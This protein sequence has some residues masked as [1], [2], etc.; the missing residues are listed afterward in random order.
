MQNELSDGVPPPSCTP[1]EVDALGG[2]AA[3]QPQMRERLLEEARRPVRAA[4]AAEVDSHSLEHY[5]TNARWSALAIV[6]AT[7]CAAALFAPQNGGVTLALWALIVVLSAAAHAVTAARLV[8]AA[9]MQPHPLRLRVVN[10]TLWL[11][12]AAIGFGLLPFIQ[13]ASTIDIAA[14]LTLLASLGVVTLSRMAAVFTP[15]IGFALLTMVP[16]SAWVVYGGVQKNDGDLAVLGASALVLLGVVLIAHRTLHRTIQ[17][18]W[19]SSME[20]RSL[21]RRLQRSNQELFADRA[22]LQNESRTDSLTGL[23]NRRRLEETLEEEWGRCR[24]AR[25]ILSC[26]ML[27][28]D[29]FKRFND[30]Y[31]HDGGDECLRRIARVLTGNLRRAGDLVARYGGEEFMLLLPNTDCAGALVVAEQLREA[32][33]RERIPHED[34]PTAPHVTISL[35][36]ASVVPDDGVLVQELPKAADLAL[37]EAKRLGRDRVVA[38]DA[39]MQESARMAAQRLIG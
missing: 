15:F 4:I 14:C 7:G 34:S 18:S 12:G 30:R 37:Y 16:P 13:Q 5:L 8:E 38:A 10:A 33:A 31:G 35:G 24:R 32:V 6:I 23:A 11:S 39:P 1:R 28:I 27:D 26:V 36:A 3:P 20:Q 9:R 29:H 17:S 22:T 19:W 2:D 21:L 25:A